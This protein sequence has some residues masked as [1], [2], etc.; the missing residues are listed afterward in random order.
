MPSKNKER[1]INSICDEIADELRKRGETLESMLEYL[2][3]M[4]EQMNEEEPAEEKK[5]KKK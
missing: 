1:D 3:R 2:R 5:P 4:R